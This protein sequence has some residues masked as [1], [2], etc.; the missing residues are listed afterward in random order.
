MMVVPASD[1]AIY[2]GSRQARAP[3]LIAMPDDKP[4]GRETSQTAEKG[5]EGVLPY[6]AVR[7]GEQV[8]SYRLGRQPDL[9]DPNVM[10]EA[11]DIYRVVESPSWILNAESVGVSYDTRDGRTEISGY[12][13]SELSPRIALLEERSRM[14]EEADG[15]LIDSV[16]ELKSTIV[17][18]AN[19]I[20]ELKGEDPLVPALEAPVG[21][22]DE[23][24]TN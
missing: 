22:E 18:L 21:E 11:H 3:S 9:K 15:L 13:Q 2:A 17:Q 16:R 10:H 8:V 6:N 4:A 5:P 14:S 19:E 7:R 23:D 1:L 12:Q 20:A 24:G